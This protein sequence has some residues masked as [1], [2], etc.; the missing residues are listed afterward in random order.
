MKSLHIKFII[1]IAVAA[2]LYIGKNR[3][4][5]INITDDEK[6][7][8]PFAAETIEIPAGI[9]HYLENSLFYGNYYNENKKFV[10]YY[11]GSKTPYPTSFA[12]AFEEITKKP[13]YSSEYAFL[14]QEFGKKIEFSDEKEAKRDAEFREICR[15]FCIVN[16]VTNELFYID[17]IG[18]DDVREIGNI[19]DGLQGW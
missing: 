15:Q 8:I 5:D 11:T 10:V 7:K 14:P 18:D 2:A 3:H 9:A 13:I 17:G 16:P 19:F 6:N 1:I 12:P 4:T